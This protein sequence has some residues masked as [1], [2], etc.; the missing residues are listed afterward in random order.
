MSNSPALVLA[1]ALILA[2]LPGVLAAQIPLGP[3][4]T[5]FRPVAGWEGTIAMNFTQSGNAPYAPGVTGSHGI[6]HIIQGTVR[7]ETSTLL[8]WMGTVTG[9]TVRIND[10]QSAPF[11]PGCTITHEVTGEGSL[12]TSAMDGQPRQVFLQF[13]SGSDTWSLIFADDGVKADWKNTQICPPAPTQVAFRPQEPIGWGPDMP[14]RLPFPASGLEL[15]GTAA[16][17]RE[18]ALSRLSYPVRGEFTYNLRPLPCAFSLSQSSFSVPAAG[19]TGFTVQVTNPV[20]CNWT[21]VNTS[22]FVIAQTGPDRVTFDVLA[23]PSSSP[24]SAT[25]AIAGL[26]VTVTQAG[27]ASGLR[28]VPLDPCRVMETRAAYNFE[29]RTGAFGPPFIPSGQTRTLTLANS[30]VCAVPSSAKAY[31]LN[32]TVIPRGPLDF[33][34]L[35]PGGTTRPNFWTVRS[36]D[37]QIV[38]NS[39]TVAAG[40]GAISVYASNDTD[41]LIDISGYF[42]DAISGGTNLVYY[43]LTP[44]RVIETRIAYRQPAS[45][46]GPPRMNPGETRIVRFPQSPHCTIP[47][48]AA[49][50]SM[51]LTVIPP[52]PLPFMTLWPAGG[53]QPNVSSINSFAG[54]ILANS[55]IVPASADGS[56][57][58]FAFARTDFLVDISGYFAPDNGQG[59]YYFPV[60]QCRAQDSTSYADDSTNTINIPSAGNCSG[61]PAT[62]KGYTIN[63]TAIPGGSALPFVT[64]YPT[65]QARPN[66]SILNAF[67]G[68]TVTG[69]GIIPAGLGGSIDVYAYRR[70]NVVVDVSGYFGR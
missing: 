15:S 53:S 9:G 48:G 37:G 4:Q 61:I 18:M 19:G 45:P 16:V 70:T 55:V 29:G 47:S 3:S 43:P 32:V 69:G 28:F 38:A 52:Q 8:G 64:V 35:W 7:L 33:V 27:T 41:M 30:N 10:Q 51:T 57:A 36:P 17:T 63:V 58:V 50:Y 20:G 5:R 39:T 34:T 49:A 21:L 2:V 68:Q 25:L 67:E 1:K 40:S 42:T 65:G 11:P 31:V 14:L 22:S 13:D 54:R 62:A 23:N 66:A 59:L 24:R 46:F 6:S 12:S 44:C 60:T 56:I 26:A